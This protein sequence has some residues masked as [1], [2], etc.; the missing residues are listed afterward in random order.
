M[1]G[2]GLARLGTTPPPRTAETE[3]LWDRG[4]PN[5]HSKAENRQRKYAVYG[6]PVRPSKETPPEFWGERLPYFRSHEFQKVDAMLN[7]RPKKKRKPKSRPQEVALAMDGTEIT[8]EA[9]AGRPAGLLLPAEREERSHATKGPL[10][11]FLSGK[12]KKRKREDAVAVNTS[13]YDMALPYEHAEP[14]EQDALAGS[15]AGTEE[16]P[17]KPDVEAEPST[18]QPQLE[19]ETQPVEAV[20]Y[21]AVAEEGIDMSDVPALA[22]AERAAEELTAAAAENGTPEPRLRVS[23]DA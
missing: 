17:I 15:S 10:P 8:A 11:G 3:H 4:I 18:E 16:A 9:E 22:E 20:E 6:R 2:R 13:V 1:P 19:P 21:Q 14:H 7:G 5:S 23:E 12:G